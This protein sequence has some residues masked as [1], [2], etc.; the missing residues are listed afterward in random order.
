M[1]FIL[2]TCEMKSDGNK[3]FL[4]L[5]EVKLDQAGEVVFKAR[6]ATSIAH[7]R[8]KGNQR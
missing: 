7:L 4:I 6:N 3:R 1:I 8:V 5:H 2:Q